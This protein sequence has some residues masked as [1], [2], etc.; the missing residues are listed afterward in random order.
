MLRYGNSN[1]ISEFVITC[2]FPVISILL[3][4]LISSCKEDKEKQ[5]P[6]VK[7]NLTLVSI[8]IDGITNTNKVFAGVSLSPNIKIDFK[9]PIDPASISQNVVL[10]S[11]VSTSIPL[12][13]A[14]ENGNSL[15]IRTSGELSPLTA[16][17]ITVSDIRSSTQGILPAPVVIKLGTSYSK[18]DKFPVITDEELLTLVQR[19]TFKYFWDFG[20]PV[21]GL[22]RERETSGD[23]VTSGGSGFTIMA[24]ITGVHRQFITR[25]EALVRMQK[26]V[27][28]LKNNAQ[29]FHGAFPHWLNGT[30]G[31]VIPFSPKDNGADLVETAYLIQGLLIARQYFSADDAA[32]SALRSDINTIWNDVEWNW[33]RRNNEDVLYWHWS[34]DFGWEMNHRIEGWNEALITYVLAASSR[35]PIPK[36]VYDKG[37]ARNGQMRNGKIYFGHQ[38]PLGPEMGGPLFFA[39]YSFLGINPKGLT[40]AYANYEAQNISHSLISYNYCKANPRGFVGYSELC[41]GLTASDDINGYR[42]HEPSGDTGVISPT[43]ALSS[44][45][46]TPDESMAALKFFYYKL[47]DRIFKEYGFVDAFSLT[48]PWVASSFLAID[49]GPQ[50]IM[51]ENHRSGLLWNLFMSCPEIKSGMRTLGFQSPNL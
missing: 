31:A 14:I 19:Q 43:A 38:L 50:I 17:T 18:A 15:V 9:E 25:A 45:P 30:T 2:R 46:Y 36:A 42:V 6:L 10:T 40:D 21:S 11:S 37:W 41:W 26:I 49:Q 35:S 44:M 33:F 51:I 24:I 7:K 5:P 34:P 47:G 29:R 22:A 32:E 4:F 3:L 28:F 13:T 1:T 20:H 8:S 39:H 27:G 23:L 48:E 16:Y 12:I